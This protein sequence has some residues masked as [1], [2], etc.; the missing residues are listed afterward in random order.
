MYDELKKFDIK[1][2]KIDPPHDRPSSN[3]KRDSSHS[4]S[5]DKNINIPSIEPPKLLHKF[6]QKERKYL[7]NLANAFYHSNQINN[8]DK[9]NSTLYKTVIYKKKKLGLSEKNFISKII[10]KYPTGH[11]INNLIKES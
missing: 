9:N 4:E 10:K 6:S 1:E 3:G 2:L 11:H 5:E 8:P 7:K